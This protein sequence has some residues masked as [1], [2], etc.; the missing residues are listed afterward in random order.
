MSHRTGFVAVVGR[1]NT[2]KS[3]L[4]NRLVG[5]KV[6]ITS[7]KAQTTRHSVL[8]IVSRDDGQVVLVDTPGF[9][10][11]HGGPLNRALNRTVTDSLGQ[12]DV[13]LYVV[14]ATRLGEDDEQVLRLV[15]PEAVVVA[16]VNKCDLLARQ[17]LLLPFIDR[18]RRAREFAAIVPVSAQSGRQCD[19]L[20]DTLVGLL[21]E[22][23]PLYDTD[24]VTDRSE[25][26]LAA[27]LVR[28]K[29]FRF[30]G[31]ELPYGVNVVVDKFETEGE[32]RRILCNV[33]VGRDSHKGMVIGAGGETLK[34]IATEA[35]L[36]MERQFGGKVF[37]ELHVR[38]DADW[39]NDPRRLRKYGYV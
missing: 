26:F 14:D 33:I 36:E 3:T 4:V 27:E 25:R 15:P 2:G 32:L 11:R 7:R 22:G 29:L 30:T 13:V 21:P 20:L 8:G 19:D 35:R 6:S 10:T 5:Q 39:Q 16:V 12:V 28:E 34:R 37:L 9:Q 24:Q 31:D 17:E 18:L 1:P 23:P 38:V